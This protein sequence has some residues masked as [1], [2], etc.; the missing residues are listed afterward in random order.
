MKTIHDQSKLTQDQITKLEKRLYDVRGAINHWTDKERV[1]KHY[2]AERLDEEA[3]IV[4]QLQADKE[5]GIAKSLFKDTFKIEPSQYDE[6]G[7]YDV[8]QWE[9]DGEVEV[10][11]CKETLWHYLYFPN[12]ADKQYY[13]V[14]GRCD[15]YL[16]TL[17][18]L[19][20]WAK[21]QYFQ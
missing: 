9:E 14:I 1:A 20:D 5:A 12:D 13:M 6:Y 17:E 2:L 4:N 18:E 8:E 15:Q 19:Q 7:V 21:P 3:D 16:N 11:V 10:Y